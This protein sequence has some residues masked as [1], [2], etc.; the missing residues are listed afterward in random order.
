MRAELIQME[1]ASAVRLLGGGGPAK[2]QNIKAA[3]L[4]RLPYTVIERLRWLKIKRIPADIADTVREAVEKHN[5]E[6]LARAEHELFIAQQANAVMAARLAEID[7]D[8]YG[9]E[10]NRLRGPDT[11]DRRG[12]DPAR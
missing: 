1:M 8:F 2:E 4:T 6:N 9:P 5:E 3:R 10:I 11:G 7:P 12:A